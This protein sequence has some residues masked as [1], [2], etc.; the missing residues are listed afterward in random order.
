MGL[1]PV[2]KTNFMAGELC[3]TMQS[4]VDS[5]RYAAGMKTLRNAIVL[6]GGGVMRRP[7]L[8]YINMVKPGLVGYTR[9]VSFVFSNGQAYVL[10]FGH[11]YVRFY[12]NGA[13]IGAP[14][15]VVTPYMAEYGNEILVALQFSQ[16][17]NMLVITHPDYQPRILT[18]YSDADWIF[19]DY[20][21]EEGP[22]MPLN[23]DA[24][25]SMAPSA[26]TGNITLTCTHN[27]FSNL[28]DKGH[29]AN[30][31]LWQVN[32]LVGSQL[33]SATLTTTG[34]TASIKCGG[35]WRI[36]THGTWTATI[37]VEMSLDGGTS[38]IPIRQ[39]AAQGTQNYN[40][41]GVEDYSHFL[42]RVNCTA[43]T[44]GPVFVDI[45]AD[46]F[47]WK[48]VVQ[49][50]AVPAGGGG[51]DSMYNTADAT[52]LTTL[53][54]TASTADWA[55]GAWSEYRGYPHA[56][57]YY[58]DRL[59]FANTISEPHT[60]WMSEVG[61]HISFGR[62]SPLLDSD[63]ITIN[64]P[65][66]RLNGVVALEP[67]RELLVLTTGG[68]WGVAATGAGGLTPTTVGVKS[69]GKHGA[70]ENV[71]PVVIGDRVLYIQRGG[72]ALRDTGY[73]EEAGG[74]EGDDLSVSASH[75][76][77]G[78]AIVEMA[79]Q[80]TPYGI[81]WLVRDDGIL[82]SLTYNR[83]AGINAWARHDTPIP[84]SPPDIPVP[85]VFAWFQS[86][87]AIPGINGQDEVWFVITRSAGGDGNPKI[88]RMTRCSVS[89]LPEDQFYVDAGHT[90]EGAET[91]VLEIYNEGADPGVFAIDDL[92]GFG[93]NNGDIIRLNGFV[94]DM[95]G[96]AGLD[97]INDVIYNVYE[98]EGDMFKLKIGAT[99][100][101]PLYTYEMGNYLYGG[102]IK[103]TSHSVS[104][105]EWLSQVSVLVDGIPYILTVD[106][107]GVLT[108]PAGVYGSYIQVGLGYTTDIE[109]LP[110]NVAGQNSLLGLEV[111][112]P[113]LKVWLLNTLGGKA[114][115]DED[116]LQT[117]GWEEGFVSGD[118]LLLLRYDAAPFKRDL[119]TGNVM[120]SL[121]T[122]CEANRSI[123][124]RQDQPLPM[125]ILAI[126]P[127]VSVPG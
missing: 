63:G 54:D 3:P 82:L 55:E 107:S 106:M 2:A 118:N 6:P 125:T 126:I 96:A 72:E 120:L 41:Y 98:I 109:I 56:V 101:K 89:P 51:G 64:L 34:A 20:D 81:V 93:L 105:L 84:V 17:A 112:I 115:Y 16:S 27:L 103:K 23:A 73:S 7:G 74:F 31:T 76:L 110:V 108:L 75:L 21:Y 22:Y 85:D 90:Q 47:I 123:M 50:T 102:T 92:A 1:V 65:S 95:P 60:I 33:T 45:S 69:Y 24:T 114:G 13:I 86:V 116:H 71:A 44:S 35:T 37:A 94:G 113:L 99:G 42:V 4:Q 127:F 18:Y 68:E 19:T 12:K 83:V 36:V 111:D 58:Q 14:Y 67:L 46:P 32:H 26:T 61:L 122:K 39:L 49:I 88:E 87:C 121:D 57:S 38:W 5:P 77:E 97:G 119:F 8:E 52:V 30:R 78:H 29:A 104:G 40:T 53:A 62:N 59:V 28:T 100:T 66:K 79:Y 48:G 11:L 80:Q 117:F 43:Y 70:A 15:E 9:L 10:E 124:I 91:A 25:I